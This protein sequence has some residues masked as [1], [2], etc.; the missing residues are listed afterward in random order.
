MIKLVEEISNKFSKDTIKGDFHLHTKYSGDAKGEIRDILEMALKNELDV[1]AITDHNEIKGAFEAKKLESKYNLKVIIGEEVR[2]SDDTDI[3]GLF[4]KDKIPSGLSEEEVIDR[5]HDQGG[6]VIAP[7]PFSF[8]RGGIGEKVSKYGIDY[9]EIYNGLSMFWENRKALK[10]SKRNN[11]PGIAGSDAHRPR[12]VG[13]A[14]TEFKVIEDVKNLKP[15]KSDIKLLKS[16]IN[17]GKR[18]IGRIKE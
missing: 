16:F 15:I 9:I 13:I 10:I 17:L 12:E 14:Y 3:I 1:I 18:F 11:L 8:Y 4:L 2:T 5:I 7:H 6:I